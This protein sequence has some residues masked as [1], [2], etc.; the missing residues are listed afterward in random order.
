MEEQ[1]LSAEALRS[2]VAALRARLQE[3]EMRSR[4]LRDLIDCVPGA[5]WESWFVEDPSRGRV[6]YV[7]RPIRDITGYTQEEWLAQPSLWSDLG[8]PEDRD[9][10]LVANQQLE[11]NGRSV[12]RCRWIR[13]D[14]EV[15]WV[16]AQTV[17]VRDEDGRAV[18]LRGIIM[19]VTTVVRA[20]QDRATALLQQEALRVKEAALL[21]LSTPLIPVSDAVMVMPLVGAIDPARAERA[22]TVLLE[23]MARSGA[24]VAILD[25]T[26]VPQVDAE[27]AD[28]LVR[29]ARS[30]T[31]LGAEPMLTGIR[32]EVA[33]TLVSLGIDLSGI[34]T[35]STLQTGVASAMRRARAL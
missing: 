15:L 17:C 11:R 24:R 14:G 30:V 1:A 25:I 21:E 31:L 27:I 28:A 23:G 34:S 2:E 10:V 22:I 26:G 3:A 9:R 35:Y 16:E 19:D 6:G 13:R 12:L 8:H 7:S 29:A 5:V 18:G 33:Q 32:P 4:M 20:E